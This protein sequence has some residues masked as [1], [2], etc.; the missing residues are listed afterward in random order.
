[1]GQHLQ[2]TLGLV[3][4]PA[5]AWPAQALDEAFQ[6]C[7][8]HGVHR[9]YHSPAV[10]HRRRRTIA[11]SLVVALHASVLVLLWRGSDASPAD[12]GAVAGAATLRFQLVSV[13]T[14]AV[15]QAIT[16]TPAVTKA[17][18]V[19]DEQTAEAAQ[20]EEAVKASAIASAG[21]ADCRPLGAGLDGLANVPLPASTTT[22]SATDLF[23]DLSFQVDAEGRALPE[24]ISISRSSGVTALDEAA[25]AYVATH[26]VAKPLCEGQLTAQRMSFRIVYMAGAVGAASTTSP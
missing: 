9:P 25:V 18:D 10:L 13:T 20:K 14:R 19:P 3:T 7:A 15:A 2:L 8:D 17:E 21:D 1:M 24:G 5:I 16:P 4:S 26:P 23:V 11:L 22:A 6:L 12:A